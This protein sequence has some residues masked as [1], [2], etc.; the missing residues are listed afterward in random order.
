MSEE[1]V[2][3]VQLD[4]PRPVNSV[5]A[6]Q[7]MFQFTNNSEFYSIIPA[8]YYSFYNNWV[9]TWLQ[10]ADGYVPYVHG[11][12]NGLLSTNIGAMIINRVTDVVVSGN[13]MFKN[14]RKPL[15]TVEKDGKT[16]GKALDFISN[17]FAKKT[18]LIGK[19]RL[20]I[21]NAF[22]GGFSLLK[23]N[24]KNGEL[25]IDSLRAD[26]FYIEK[27]GSGEIRKVV[28]VLSFYD[29]MTQG[30]KLGKKYCLIEER[31]Y[32][33]F[34]MFDEE[35]PVVEYKIYDSSVQIQYFTGISDNCITW[36]QL[37]KAV[38]KA[39]KSEYGDCMLNEPKALNLSCLGV[40]LLKGSDDISNV[41]QINLGQS[42]LQNCLTYLYEYDFQNTAF[43][44]DM[45]LGRGRVIA[46]KHMQSPL[47][48]GGTTPTGLDDFLYTKYDGANAEEQK[49]IPVQF[50]I[51]SG[52]WEATKKN[53]LS[54]IAMSIG[55]STSTLST[56]LQD[57]SA[58]TAREVSAEENQTVLF[59]ENNRRR[60]EYSINEMLSEVL[61]YYG[62][63][64][65][66]EIRWSRA[67]MTNQ[68]VLVDTLS[69]AVQSGLMSKKKAHHAFNY[70]EDEEQNEE[71]F[72]LVE[73]ESKQG[74][75]EMDESLFYTQGD[76]RP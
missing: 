46:P 45:Y 37:P 70:D 3:A 26:R 44:T 19:I 32:E 53:L 57:G 15:Q 6:N 76:D 63:T 49:P 55:I 22:A 4:K 18:D 11:M 54:C 52:E 64:D 16:V 50:E 73:Q 30:N 25:W 9:K 5:V 24:K 67:G 12:N 65:D 60:F 1:L 59:V 10:W 34:G 2:N 36:E 74:G 43:N 20:A 35:I 28:S 27:V 56:D 61:R 68:T 71:D 72:A 58:K 62:Y 17:N 40:Y 23:I 13:V 48:N 14:A 31:R 21:K 38:R 69:R 29:D 8:P 66:V 41:P 75:G 39:F 33:K 51:R 47:A 7:T 42:I